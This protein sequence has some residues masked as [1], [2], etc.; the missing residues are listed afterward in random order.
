MKL[1]DDVVWGLVLGGA[2]DKAIPLT[3]A[4]NTRIAAGV[5]TAY[6]RDRSAQAGTAQGENFWRCS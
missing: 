1:R 2:G 3:R 4:P 6:R 5:S